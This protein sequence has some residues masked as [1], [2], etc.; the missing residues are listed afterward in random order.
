MFESTEH[1]IIR[2]TEEMEGSVFVQT[3]YTFVDEQM[4]GTCCSTKQFEGY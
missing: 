4:D 2:L 3:V 1:K